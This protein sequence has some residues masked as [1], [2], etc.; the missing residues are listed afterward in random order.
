[1]QLTASLPPFASNPLVQGLAGDQ[2]APPIPEMTEFMHP[3]HF[4]DAGFAAVQ[5]AADFPDRQEKRSA[6]LIRF[7]VINH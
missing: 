3:N 7:G 5:Q 6:I 1:M 4:V 2:D